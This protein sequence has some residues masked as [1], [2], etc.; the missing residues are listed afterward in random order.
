[1]AESQK[2]TP[3]TKPKEKSS[4]L[5]EEIGKEFLSSWK[6]MS[7]TEDDA[8][9]FSFEAVS[10]GQKKKFNFEKLDMDFNLD[11]D[12]DKLSSFK[13]DMSDLDFLSSPR[14]TAKPKERC[15]EESSS[16][17]RQ[18]KQDRFNFSFDFNVLDSFS[19]ESSLTKEDKN[20]NTSDSKGVTP[21][22]SQCQGSKLNLTEGNAGC[23]DCLDK[24]LQAC[25]SAGM[26]EVENLIGGQGDLNFINDGSTSKSATSE[27]LVGSH[28]G[29][30][31]S[32]KAIIMS[33][34]ETDQQKS[35]PENLIF[36]GPDAQQLKPDLP[37]QPMHA[38]DSNRD[39][40]SDVSEAEATI[41][42]LATKEK[43]ASSREQI[44]VD[45]VTSIVGSDHENSPRKNSP[46]VHITGS[47]S[48]DGERN[49]S[50]GNAPFKHTNDTEPA[51]PVEG[52]LDIK[53][54]S[55][56]NA[57]RK[58]AY[59]TKG[60]ME[61]QRS[62]SKLPLAPL[63]REHVA[64]T[65]PLAKENG[66][67]HSMFNTR[68]EE[69]GSPLHQTPR[70]GFPSFGSKRVGA[71]HLSP[72]SDKGEG[73]NINDAQNECK[74]VSS[75][76]SVAKE[77]T[78]GQPFFQRSEKN[79]KNL[80][81]IRG[82]LDSDNVPNGSNLIENSQPHDKEV[83]KGELVLFGSGKNAK[84]HQTSRGGL[85]SDN[86]PN[87][88][89]LIE[90]SQSRDKEVTKGELVLLGSER[91]VKYHQTSSLTEK[92]TG[93]SAQTRVNPK[94]MLLSIESLRNSEI[95]P[96]E[97]NKLCLIN[98]GKKTPDLSSMR[99]ARTIGASKA[100]SNSICQTVDSSGKFA[101]N[102]G[103]EG[104]TTSK[105]VHL[106]GS[107]EKQM[108]QALSLK[109]KKFEASNADSESLK[110][111][112]RLSESPSESS[113][114]KV[115]SERVLEEQVCIR[116]IRTESNAKHITDDQPTSGLESPREVNMMELEI[117][118]VMETD[119]NVEKAE[120][121]TKELDDICNM[122][123]KKHEEAK[124]IL[125]RAIVNNNNLLMLNHP[126]YEEKIRKIQN[127]AAKLLPKELRT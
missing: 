31:S 96:A 14:N 17:N 108:S 39:T 26:S 61:S 103:V 42:S 84:D 48:N 64:D 3:S 74:S 55:T 59:D 15:E 44:D 80:G 111:L 34:G 118:L 70:M 52:D 68:K 62:T 10:K 53:D 1:M 27:N 89:K 97:R 107:D 92:T 91:N 35:V 78:K 18:Q 106:V 46:P 113:N 28:G 50:G 60:I 25:K 114:L 75:T 81:K 99:T 16:G 77:F 100:L 54:T 110:S 67:I 63:G 58:A 112:K 117:P 93:C 4:L 37:V 43:N 9:D 115:P 51:E 119:G 79:N 8:M 87:G 11:G 72:A 65:R 23:D 21:E 86:M 82:G 6:S 7:V 125:V 57:S 13:V 123:K 12:F 71:M 24:K 22:L 102:V 101:Q 85:D 20:S 76:I 105:I 2:G 32:R 122:L 69:T 56:K 5:D 19:F 121:Y 45:K 88:S 127:F 90:N 66:G 104:N 109:R 116:G 126:I 41:C 124:E 95:I 29:G 98:A 40:V 120:A 94:L 83:T 30:T 73:F 47:D 36:A 38:S 33:V 49:K